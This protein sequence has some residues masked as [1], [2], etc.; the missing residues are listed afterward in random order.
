MDRGWSEYVASALAIAVA[1]AQVLAMHQQNMP[2]SI[3]SISLTLLPI[4][5][6]QFVG[7][8]VYNGDS[9]SLAIGVVFAALAL[10][11]AWF[12]RA[13]LDRYFLLLLAAYCVVCVSVA[14][15]MPIASLA[16]IDPFIGA[17]RYFFYPFTLLAWLLVWLAAS[18]SGPVRAAVAAVFACSVAFSWHGLTRHHR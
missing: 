16:D 11:A 12:N 14:V 2:V 5:L 17:P 13:H 4:S 7:K 15:R 3:E 10:G 6:K 8:F 9:V 1:V 18:S